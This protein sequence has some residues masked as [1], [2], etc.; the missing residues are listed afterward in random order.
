M[1][2]PDP[3]TDW[4]LEMVHALPDDGNRYEL[5]DGELLVSP[6]PSLLHQRVVFGLYDRLREYVKRLGWCELL[7]AP[8][9][10]TFSPRRELQPD[11]CVIP[12][13]NGRRAR[14]F[15]DVGRLVLAV[16]VLSP[17]TTRN[18]R[19]RKR[20]VYQEE[21]ADECWLVDPE[22]RLV[23]RWRPRDTEPEVLLTTLAWQPDALREALEVDL[24][25]LF[26]DAHDDPPG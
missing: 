13:V 25:A 8:I 19:Y 10:A 22:A 18:D 1:A 4:T 17:G 9:A 3:R 16:E 6:A 24:E 15:E 14:R 20:P 12:L 23:E 7:G 21:G 11:L 26:R 2:M 5:V